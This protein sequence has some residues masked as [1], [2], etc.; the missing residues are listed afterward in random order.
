[1]SVECQEALVKGDPILISVRQQGCWLEARGEVLQ[2]LDQGYVILVV[3]HK[4]VAQHG[5]NCQE[6][7]EIIVG[8]EEIELYAGDLKRSI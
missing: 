2:I 3:L 1:M 5:M 6:G 4:I 7:D 8:R